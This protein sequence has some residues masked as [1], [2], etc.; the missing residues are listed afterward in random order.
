MITVGLPVHNSESMVAGAIESV[1]QQD[2]PDVRVLVADNASTDL[3]E[4]VC[5]EIAA[6]DSR[7]R[8]VR[9]PV[10]IGMIPNFRWLADTADGEWFA[11]LSADDR[12]LTGFL[13]ACV[14]AL[15]RDPGVL[16]AMTRLADVDLDDAASRPVP[17]VQPLA[18]DAPV[19]SVR[20]RGLMGDHQ[21]LPQFGV[22]RLSVL[23][24]IRPYS[25]TAEGDRVLLAELALRGRIVEIPEVLY[26]RGIHSAQSMQVRSSTERLALMYPPKAGAI[27][28]PAWR[29]GGEL[30]RA[31]WEA[32]LSAAE[33]A[34]CW[35]SMGRWVAGNWQKLGRNVARAGIEVWQ[36]R[37]LSAPLGESIIGGRS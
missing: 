11:W 8:Y 37:G 21:C 9:H 23:R 4:D 32:P 19:A 27:P 26:H 15:E 30:A 12:M 25:W 14:D 17:V 22:Y 3:T 36:R 13:R 33:K 31:V 7:V 35:M 29:L 28:F 6:R 2:V 16:L 10:D 18:T 24:R 20:F 5:R 1:L 34:V